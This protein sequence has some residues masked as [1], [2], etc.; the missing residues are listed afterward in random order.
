MG[1]TITPDGL[2]LSEGKGEGGEHGWQPFLEEDGVF[3]FGLLGLRDSSLNRGRRH[4]LRRGSV[5]TLGGFG[6]L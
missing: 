1:T 3:A 5:C 4:L 2:E 6:T